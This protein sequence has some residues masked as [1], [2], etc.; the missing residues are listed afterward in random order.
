MKKIIC[1]AI[2]VIIFLLPKLEI[3][4]CNGSCLYFSLKETLKPRWKRDSCVVHYSVNSSKIIHQTWK[5]QDLP[6]NFKEWSNSW[7]KLHPQWEYKLWTDNDN[8]ELVKSKYPWFLPVYDNLPLTINR[9]DVVRFLYLHAFGGIYADLDV[10]AIHAMDSIHNSSEIVFGFM[11]ISMHRHNIPNAFMSS[12]GPNH[13]FWLSALLETVKRSGSGT[14]VE[15]LTG[16][17]LLTDIVNEWI[18]CTDKKKLS[19][20]NPTIDLNSS[21]IKVLRSGLIYPYDWSIRNK[22][23]E[24]FCEPTSNEFNNTLCKNMFND[25]LTMSYWTHTWK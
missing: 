18:M 8:R 6:P 17:V 5:T 24:L 20:H 2:V 14:F 4:F 3:G 12:K 25:A 10:E 23:V 21:Q 7:K 11:S 1:L 9:V 19:Q 13:P 16:P 22:S 15:A